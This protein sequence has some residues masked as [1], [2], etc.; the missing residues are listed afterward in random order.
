MASRREEEHQRD[1]RAALLWRHREKSGVRPAQRTSTLSP[2][3]LK[4]RMPVNT[5]G[6]LYAP[7]CSTRPSPAAGLGA[8]G[9]LD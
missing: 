6:A 2:N 7:G 5:S 3:C 8:E 4:E 1:L 9:R